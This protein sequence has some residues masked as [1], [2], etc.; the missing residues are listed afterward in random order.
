MAKAIQEDKAV[1]VDHAEILDF[2]KTFDNVPHQ[3]LLRKLEYYGIRG[4]LAYLI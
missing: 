4:N 1:H 3:S 2:S